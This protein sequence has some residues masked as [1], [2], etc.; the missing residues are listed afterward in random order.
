MCP[1]SAM[2]RLHLLCFMMLWQP[3]RLLLK[4]LYVIYRVPDNDTEHK[5]HQLYKTEQQAYILYS[6][7]WMIP[8][9]RNFM[10]RRFGTLF[11]I[12]IGGVRSYLPAY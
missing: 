4:Y 3:D 2:L 9:R 7:F 12:F 11:S 1:P 10:C 8:R 6:F 5:R